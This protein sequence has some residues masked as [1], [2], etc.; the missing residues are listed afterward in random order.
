MTPE[1]IQRAW[2]GARKWA[3]TTKSASRWR[4]SQLHPKQTLA[5]MMGPV[6]PTEKMFLGVDLKRNSK[7]DWRVVKV[8]H[9]SPAEAAGILKG[10]TL[11]DFDNVHI[12]D[13]T[14]EEV[15]DLT[16]KFEGTKSHV[17]LRPPNTNV[18]IERIVWYSSAKD[19]T[20]RFKTE[21]DWLSKA[22]NK[23]VHGVEDGLEFY[24]NQW[25]NEI[26]LK[27]EER[28]EHWREMSKRQGNETIHDT[29]MTTPAV[30]PRT[31]QSVGRRPN[32]RTVSP[33]IAP[34]FHSG[35]SRSLSAEEKLVTYSVQARDGASERYHTNMQI[36]SP[37]SSGRR[38]NDT[39]QVYTVE[40]VMQSPDARVQHQNEVIETIINRKHTSVVSPKGNTVQF[41]S[42]TSLGSEHFGSTT[43]VGTKTDREGWTG[44]GCQLERRHSSGQ[45]FVSQIKPGCGCAASGVLPGSRLLAV[46]GTAVTGFEIK[47]IRDMCMG[48]IGSKTVLRLIAPEDVGRKDELARSFDRTIWRIEP[49]DVTSSAKASP[50]KKVHPHYSSM[51]I[52][53]HDEELV[54][55]AVHQIIA[56]NCSTR[57]RAEILSARLSELITPRY[58]DIEKWLPFEDYWAREIGNGGGGAGSALDQRANSLPLPKVSEAQ[59]RKKR[60]TF[61][62]SS[63]SDAELIA[64]ARRLMNEPVGPWEGEYYRASE[65]DELLASK[66]LGFGD[67]QAKLGDLV[68]TVNRMKGEEQKGSSRG[69]PAS[70]EQK[71]DRAPEQQPKVWGLK[72]VA[73]NLT[74]MDTNIFLGR[75]S[76]AYLLL[77]QEKQ[78]VGKT[79]VVPRSLNPVWEKIQVRLN[80]AAK[81]LIRCFDEDKLTAD[82]LIGEA[83][84]TV[85]QLTTAGT[86]IPLRRGKE[87]GGVVTVAAV[88]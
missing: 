36:Y 74:A 27:P 52:E 15:R 51:P 72:L 16:R 48:P 42:T 39:G 82:D 37:K 35:P 45:I 34:Q 28:E 9:D 20:S 59:M 18:T 63:A 50:R 47:R 13:L 24:H 57:D 32:S 6:V 77:Y 10:S 80:P 61:S 33:I 8:H 86:R 30:T 3:S 38:L 81:V 22:I 4:E 65:N 56:R 76:D 43:S 54:E 21:K 26:Q 29:P 31:P 12:H 41:K 87:D 19:Q 84:V 66:S 53:R 44:V 5:M 2:H 60:H 71:V 11:V 79:S 70:M 58:V 17:R 7:G 68:N 73:A 78:L 49:G 69:L 23:I 83:E 46:D 55:N 1:Q 40:T 67:L 62:Q 75:S 14:E 64:L 88:E 85:K 25:E